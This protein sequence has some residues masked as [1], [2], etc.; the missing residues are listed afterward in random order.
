MNIKFLILILVLSL[1]SCNYSERRNIAINSEINIDT[2]KANTKF[3]INDS[4]CYS[5]INSYYKQFGIYISTY[6]LIED[7]LRI[8]LNN[9]GN[10]DMLI[11]LSPVSLELVEKSNCITDSF[12]KRLL[13]EIISNNEKYNIGNVYS[14]LISDIGGG[15]SAYNGIYLTKNGFAIEHQ[16]GSKYSFNYIMEFNINS[17]SDILLRQIRKVCSCEGH[18]RKINYNYDNYDAHKIN[19]NDTLKTNCNCDSIWEKLEKQN[20]NHRKK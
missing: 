13:V 8:D 14:N 15:L 16:R 7:S 9:D 6:F 4:I 12:P 5:L 1:I 19:L 17:N 2:L 10:K 3:K 18:E 20:Y 11:V